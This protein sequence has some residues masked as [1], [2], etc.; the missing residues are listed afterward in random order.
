MRF[1]WKQLLIQK[2]VSQDLTSHL[3][4]RNGEVGAS[5]VEPINV[6]RPS[7]PGDDRYDWCMI[8]QGGSGKEGLAVIIECQH[9]SACLK[10]PGFQ[11]GVSFKY[12]ANHIHARRG[13]QVDDDASFSSVFEHFENLLPHRAEPRDDHVSFAAHGQLFR[14]ETRHVL[15]AADDNQDVPGF[16]R[17]GSGCTGEVPTLP[18]AYHGNP[19]GGAQI[20]LVYRF[21]DQDAVGTKS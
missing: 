9:D 3:P 4:H 15:G 8:A 12:I 16:K 10:H 19:M 18:L 5:S 1:D 13:L 17:L 20:G 6:L 21:A 7:N 14:L 2:V 11:E